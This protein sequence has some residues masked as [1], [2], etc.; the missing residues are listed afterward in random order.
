M[1]PLGRALSRDLGFLLCRQLEHRRLVGRDGDLVAGP[2]N[3]RVRPRLCQLSIVGVV[4]HGSNVGEAVLPR[5]LRR[6]LPL[7]DDVD[8]EQGDHRDGRGHGQAQRALHP[9]PT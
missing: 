8:A 4:P 2:E 3:V 7:A 5:N 1:K 6:R 9:T